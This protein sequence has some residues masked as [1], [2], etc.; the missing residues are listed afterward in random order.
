[1]HAWQSIQGRNSVN[2]RAVHADMI[3][4]MT[5]GEVTT[6]DEII[7]AKDKYFYEM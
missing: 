2:E 6:G 3:K 7:Y 4:S 1:M 5:E